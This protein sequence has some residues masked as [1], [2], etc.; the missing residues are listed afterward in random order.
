MLYNLIYFY[1]IVN[2]MNNYDIINIPGG[3][4]AIFTPNKSRELCCVSVLIRCGS[5][6]EPKQYHGLSHFLEHMMFKS[7]LDYPELG[8]I[9]KELDRI[10]G[11]YNATTSKNVTN[12]FICDLIP[13]KVNTAIDILSSMALR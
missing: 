11:N 12:Y 2:T 10:G 1:I 9:S 4:R 7:T 5:R 3:A 8:D 6:N 13:N